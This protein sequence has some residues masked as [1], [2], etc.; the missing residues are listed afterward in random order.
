MLQFWNL[1]NAK[2]WQSGCSAFSGLCRCRGLLVVLGIILVGQILIVTFGGEVFRTVPLSPL[3]WLAIIAL[4]SLTLWGG[5]L[6]R[7]FTARHEP[8]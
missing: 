1:L 3:L 8:S 5:E 6:I 7:F 2:A 4:T